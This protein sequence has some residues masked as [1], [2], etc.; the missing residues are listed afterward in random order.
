MGLLTEEGRRATDVE[1]V[2]KLSLITM[3]N[4]INLLEKDQMT[5]QGNMGADNV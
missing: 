1:G 2:E 5:L 3:K 4:E